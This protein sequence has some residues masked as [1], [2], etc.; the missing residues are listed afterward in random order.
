MQD[1][2]NTSFDMDQLLEIMKRLRKECPWDAKQTHD[3]LKRFLIEEAYEVLDS[4]DSENWDELSF[5]LGD[6]LL[7]IV[8]H[9]EIA[10]ENGLFKFDDVVNKISN[11]LVDRHP[12]VFGDRSLNTSK[13]VQQNWEQTKVE[14]EDRTSLLEG[15][16]NSAPALLKAQRLQDK[17]ASVGFDWPE[18]TPVFEKVE[19]EFQEL[20]EAY[21]SKDNNKIKNEFGDLV[22]A[23]VNLGRFMKID[24]ENA[25]N[26]SNKKFVRRFN[27]IEKKYNNDVSEMKKASLEEMDAHWNEAKKYEKK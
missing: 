24:A 16:P 17:A 18:I 23:M 15:V 8:F 12:H 5:E 27:F 3:S 25:L 21:R 26:L 19:E 20:M 11:K 6:L 14:N 10:S 4:I 22:F 9:S 7:Q 13:E 1:R 2:N